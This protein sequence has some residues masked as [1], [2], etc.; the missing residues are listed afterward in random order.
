VLQVLA[1]AGGVTDYAKKK[2]IYILRKQNGKEVKIPFNYEAVIKGEG[3]EQNISV[4]PDD[5]IVV[6]H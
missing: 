5:T 6:P 3:M 4:L 1:E 2:K